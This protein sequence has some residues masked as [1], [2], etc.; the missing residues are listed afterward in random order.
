M[1]AVLLSAGVT[2]IIAAVLGGGLQAFDVN[3]PVITS[4]ARQVLL[5][6]VGVAFVGAAWVLREPSGDGGVAEYR[7]VVA[8]SCERVVA[9]TG[10]AIGPDVYE[11]PI[12]NTFR[13]DAL[14]RDLR[15]RHR[16]ISAELTALWQ[17]PAPDPLRDERAAAERAAT[18]W[19]ARFA[20]RLDDLQAIPKD[21]LSQSDADVLSDGDDTA[22]RVR[23]NDAM[24]AL[25]GRNCAVAG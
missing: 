22:M 10:R 6:A 14:V 1:N 17:R 3:V 21:V 13:K 2:A 16:S 25:A 19:L 24:S 9:E 5:F 8:A 20:Q 23:V 15:G 18:D 4:R 11:S 12:D 7:Q